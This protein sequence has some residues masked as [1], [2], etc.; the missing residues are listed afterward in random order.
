MRPTALA[1]YAAEKDLCEAQIPPS[2]TKVLGIT[3]TAAC[4][5]PCCLRA[6][7]KVREMTS[8]LV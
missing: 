7:T 3:S 8:M 6:R 5:M 1:S 2:Q 4:E